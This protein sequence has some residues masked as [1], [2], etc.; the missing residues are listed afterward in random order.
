MTEDTAPETRL[1]RGA[2][3][4]L[5]AA[6]K[7]LRCDHRYPVQVVTDAEI[8]RINATGRPLV[9]CLDCGSREGD[10]EDR[11]YVAR[12]LREPLAAWMETVA[13]SYAALNHAA[14]VV[15]TPD[16][17]EEW[18]AESERIIRSGPYDMEQA[19]AV[20]RAIKPAEAEET[21][22]DD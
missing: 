20:A 19:L 15:L 21:T 5:R 16:R 17:S 9:G 14:D 18:T 8:E 1:E 11:L 10:R 22:T 4:E 7:V 13:V 12:H 6:A 3:D 2:A